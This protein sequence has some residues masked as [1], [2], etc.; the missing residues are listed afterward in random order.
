MV[1]RYYILDTEYKLGPVKGDVL[2]WEG[3]LWNDSSD[4]DQDYLV[5]YVHDYDGFFFIVPRSHLV[6]FVSEREL[7]DSDRK[8]D[9]P[10]GQRK[11]WNIYRNNR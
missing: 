5:R 10:V 1:K 4:I 3:D 9:G 2:V 11:I 8:H 6:E 7:E